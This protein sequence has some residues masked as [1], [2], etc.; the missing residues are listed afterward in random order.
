MRR[1]GKWQFYTIR[2]NRR[3]GIRVDKGTYMRDSDA[4]VWRC[5]YLRIWLS[6]TAYTVR[7]P[8]IPGKTKAAIRQELDHSRRQ[9]RG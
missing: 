7:T 5:W 3:W 8:H 2:T 4:F 1:L 9:Q 6:G